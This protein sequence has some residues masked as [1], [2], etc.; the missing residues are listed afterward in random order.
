MLYPTFVVKVTS[1]LEFI[2]RGLLWLSATASLLWFSSCSSHE[3]GEADTMNDRAYAFHYR[4]RDSVVV[5]AQKAMA[6]SQQNGY[7]DGEAE[8]LNHL[9]FTD[10]CRLDFSK[11]QQRLDRAV[12]IT[13][14]QLEL[15][16][17]YVQKMHVNRLLSQNRDFYA[18]REKA[19][20]CHRR[21]NE[22]KEMLTGR[23][24]KRRIYVESEYNMV[25]AGY[26]N[27]LGQ[28]DKA[29]RQLHAIN[30][31]GEIRQDTAQYLKYVCMLNA[32]GMNDDNS[33]EAV[34]ARF[35][36]LV[37]CL[38]LSRK[39]DYICMASLAMLRIGEYLL[40][41]QALQYLESVNSAG[42]TYINPNGVD[43]RYIAAWN[44]ETALL[45]F[46]QY[47]D[48]YHTAESYL[49]LAACCQELQE[50]HAAIDCLDRASALKNIQKVQALM[51][52]I[53]EQYSVAFSALDN[54]Q[55][56]DYHRNLFLDLRE[57]TRQDRYLE[58]RAEQLDTMSAQLNLM[59]ASVILAILLLVFLLYY[60][61]RVSKRAGR[62]SGV[63]DIVQ[64]FEL[65]KKVS[66]GEKAQLLE[67]H[68]E[69]S[70]QLK[71][72]RIKLRKGEED[73]LE[74]R[75]KLQMID[76]IMPLIERM[77]HE[78]RMLKERDEPEQQRAGRRSYVA[79]LAAGIDS[80]NAMLTRW[81]ELRQGQLRLHIETF[82]LQPLF[83]MMEKNKS[84]FSVKGLTLNVV[85]TTSVVKADKVLTMFMINTLAD[86]ARKFTPEGGSVTVDSHETD[87]YV[88]I[89]VTDTGRGLSD[90]ERATIFTHNIRSGHG[91]GLLN[92]RGIIE[93]Y[94][95]LS[96]LF[97]PCVLDVESVPGRG[98][99][100]YFRL[101]RGVAR[102]LMAIAML[103]G[104]YTGSAHAAGDNGNMADA[105][106]YA[107]S[108]YYSNIAA[109]Y[110]R[111][112]MFSDSCRKY[113]N[114]VVPKG[115]KTMLRDDDGSA[116]APEIQWFRDS[117]GI[118]F[119]VILDI[120]NETAVA[121]LALHDWQLYRYNNRIYTQLFQEMSADN[122]LGQY[123]RMVERQQTDKTV[124]VIM[125]VMVLLMI[126]PAYYFL[127]YRKRMLLKRGL[128]QIKSLETD[129]MKQ[130]ETAAKRVISDSNEVLADECRLAES[131]LAELHVSN[132]VLDNC[133]STI[134]H[135]TMYYPS[136]I[137]QMLEKGSGT[138]IDVL[139]ELVGYY[140]D[141]Y[142]ML[143]MQ[144]RSQTVRNFMQIRH[145]PLADVL[146]QAPGNVIV[147]ADR[148][149][150]EY[151][152]RLL[153]R[154]N[155]EAD[156]CPAI[157]VHG[158]SV[159]LTA[160]GTFTSHTDYMLCRQI[161]REH[162][163]ATAHRACGIRCDEGKIT[164]T[165]RGYV[166]QAPNN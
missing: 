119:N 121:A 37:N 88:E 80:H 91:F 76:G 108:A 101:P 63:A 58:S 107:D 165:I 98:S 120:R 94:K 62:D 8:A 134:K 153:R 73:N 106:R 126:L 51:A 16:A 146:P 34:S 44:A 148:A 162:G 142:A 6:V 138:D 28:D 152:F 125:L 21:I 96:R 33:P 131:T 110:D 163:E 5:F 136:R 11:A 132:S 25:C 115:E 50:Y 27:V 19:D 149:M 30:S 48:G 60:F 66:D 75:A 54:K 3:G 84:S 87:G 24:Q 151:L 116:V 147:V 89:A 95:K 2:A 13:D 61:N 59:I 49:R 77:R 53:H 4:N 155:K 135:E 133:L 137:A 150:L 161:L 122:T 92:C 31:Y 57:A 145:I 36:E 32:C 159:V 45:N 78:V 109:T 10:I 86:N 81:I 118:D 113:L 71:E 90:A 70:E 117:V 143:G 93:K 104:F 83:Y 102:T 128:R 154:Q 15:M 130:E 103:C 65:W 69:L 72:T 82:P 38:G 39:K 114:A 112:V 123:C 141:I 97:A 64:A 79:E 26:Y 23:Q 22:E 55:Q 18:N 158:K 56:S 124:T 166:D 1:L 9:A 105:R 35:T 41:P 7:T 47:G 42:I 17:A 144:A 99:R 40:M 68:E 20:A 74:A 52:D 111:T 140:G 85:P 139:D 29:R 127:F 43:D 164:V 14:N 156:F 12:E 67:R 100:F 157:H 160:D 129:R 46:E